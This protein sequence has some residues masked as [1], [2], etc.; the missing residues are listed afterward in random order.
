MRFSTVKTAYLSIES[1]PWRLFLGLPARRPVFELTHFS[2]GKMATVSQ[3]TIYF[4]IH[5]L[6]LEVCILN[7][8]SVRFVPKN[9]IDNKSALILVMVWHQTG[10][11][12]SS[13]PML[14]R[15]IDAYNAALRGDELSHWKS[16]D[17]VFGCPIFWISKT[18]IS[19]DRKSDLRTKN[20]IHICVLKSYGVCGVT[21]LNI[22]IR[23]RI[24]NYYFSDVSWPAQ[25]ANFGH[26][27]T[28]F[29][30]QRASNAGFVVF[31]LI[32]AQT[33]SFKNKTS[34]C[35]WFEPGIW[36]AMMRLSVQENARFSHVTVIRN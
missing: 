14:T 2:L 3:T 21:W 5:V 10:G 19:R 9:P 13:G 8:N 17:F 29:P 25:G 1:P 4:E 36:D 18:L 26:W 15:F 11:K 24:H 16:F 33:N 30:S 7:R 32:L 12:I 22:T 31:S 27:W 20:H 35:R 28:G 34:S 6:E 23:S